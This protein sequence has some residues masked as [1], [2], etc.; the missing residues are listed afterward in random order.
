MDAEAAR[1]FASQHHHA[2]LATRRRDG[3]PQMSPV[4]V[5]VDPQGQLAVSS[6]ETAVKVRNLRRHPKYDLVVFTNNFFGP[7]ISIRG[8]VEVVSLPEALP[9]LVQYYRDL[10]GE[11]PDWD[12]YRAAM[13]AERRVLLRLSIEE[14]GP[15]VSG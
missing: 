2:I 5:A 4:A 11:H 13:V 14:V 12:E 15:K 9:L 6:R 1:Q 10:S 3:S 7:W 8:E